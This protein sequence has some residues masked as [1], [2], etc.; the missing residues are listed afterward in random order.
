MP[1]SQSSILFY[2][3]ILFIILPV[4]LTLQSRKYRRS[5]RIRDQAINDGLTQ[6]TSL[7]PVINPSLCLGSMAC[8]AACPEGDIIGIIRGKAELV[9]PS[10]CIGHGA[11]AAACPHDAITLVFGTEHRGVDIPDIDLGF[12]T[13]E[14]G[15]FISG[16]LG[17]MGLVRNAILQGQ[18]AVESIIKRGYTNRGTE[19]DIVIVGAGPAGLSA[20]LKAKEQS[21]KYLLLEQESAGGTIAHYPR[22]KVVMTS[23]VDLPLYGKLKFREASKEEL[24]Q[25]W[26]SIIES[27]GLKITLNSRVESIHRDTDSFIISSTSGKYTSSSVLLAMGRRGTPRKLGVDVEELPKEVYSL[28]DPEQYQGCAILIV[29][30][31]DSALEAALSLAKQP[32]T[33]VT[34]SYRSGAFSRAK[35]KNRQ[36]IE[37]AITDKTVTVLYSSTVSE[38]LD[39]TV[40]LLQDEQ[41]ITLENDIVIINAGGILPTG[42]LKS[43]GIHVE[44]KYGTA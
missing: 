7:H 43:V 19:Y 3:L 40:T 37:Q 4:Y 35:A 2:L 41:V 32:D 25:T 14:K 13:S 8:V 36:R 20:A 23:P 42:F 28:I 27:T 26:H 24:M 6:P 18:Q 12:E 1:D 31:G 21:L 15:I 34:L 30:G 33:T 38:I 29:G 22:G 10:N 44:T 5:E 9:S 16:E 17:G 11:C 39:D